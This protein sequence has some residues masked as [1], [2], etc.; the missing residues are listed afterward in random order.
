MA[1]NRTIRLRSLDNYTY[2]ENRASATLK[3]GMC[4]Q[5]GSD[6]RIAPIATT[7]GKIAPQRIV[8]ED[9]MRGMTVDD[10]YASGDLVPNWIPAPGDRANLLV[11]AA[12]N[13]TYGDKIITST[14]G[15]YIKT[16]GTPAATYWEARETLDLTA[17]PASLVACERIA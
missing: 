15:T 5:L 14:D 6:G 1:A 8:L 9:L 17:L 7:A 3:P 12:E 13:I 11:K 10:S 4:G 2:E 16:T